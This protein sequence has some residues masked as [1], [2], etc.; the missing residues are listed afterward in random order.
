MRR[1]VF[2]KVIHLFKRYLTLHC[3]PKNI[4]KLSI[5]RYLTGATLFFH[6]ILAYTRYLTNINRWHKRYLKPDKNHMRYFNDD[7]ALKERIY[8]D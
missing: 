3:W 8:L 1:M 7:D 6:R 5:S 4:L 2:S